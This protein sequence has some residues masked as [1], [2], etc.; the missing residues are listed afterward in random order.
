MFK[1]TFSA[2]ALLTTFS[3]SAF[4]LTVKEGDVVN[5]IREVSLS[6]VRL[7]GQ[8]ATIL[9][10]AKGISVYTFDLD[11]PGNSNCKGS[12]LTEWPPLHV[13]A[14]EALP[15]PFGKITG[16]D[17][18]PPAH[19]PGDAFVLL[20]RRQKARRCV[21]RLPEMAPGARDPLIESRPRPGRAGDL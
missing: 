3:A 7:R 10:D 19:P 17:G 6:S 15:A 18:K 8:N 1:L 13:A 12:C 5:K 2:L 14:D 21:R 4:A 9:A 11:K 20:R 16:N